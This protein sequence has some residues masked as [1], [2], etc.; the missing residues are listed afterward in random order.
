MII[1]SYNKL[2]TSYKIDLIIVYLNKHNFKV[3]THH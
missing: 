2:Q 3:Y 1:I